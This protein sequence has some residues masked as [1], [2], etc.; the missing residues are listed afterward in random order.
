MG[1]I[2]GFQKTISASSRV[3]EMKVVE[4]D[5]G[6]RGDQKDNVKIFR[7]MPNSENEKERE[8]YNEGNTNNKK[9]K[10]K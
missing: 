9:K 5:W 8:E 3:E 10:I 4:N 1:F 2:S 7:Y 6:W